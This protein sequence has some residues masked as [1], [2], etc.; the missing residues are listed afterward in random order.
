VVDT[1]KPVISLAMGEKILHVSDASD[2][3]K[4][5]TAHANPAS[6][7]FVVNSDLMAEEQEQQQ[8]GIFYLAAVGGMVVVAALFAL[9]GR[10]KQQEELSALV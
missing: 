6:T 7:R 4:S 1:L 5:D 8:E 2:L 9:S 3:S 10:R